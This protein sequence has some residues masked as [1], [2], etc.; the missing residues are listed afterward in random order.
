MFL[1]HTNNAIKKRDALG[2]IGFFIKL[3]V[4]NILNKLSERLWTKATQRFWR[5]CHLFLANKETFIFSLHYS[6]K[7]LGKEKNQ[8]Q[9]E[10]FTP[11]KLHL[12]S[13][14]R[15]ATTQKKNKCVGKGFKVISPASS[16][17]QV[18]VHT[19]IPNGS[20]VGKTSRKNVSVVTNK[21]LIRKGR[22]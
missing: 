19:S 21:L 5:G 11:N 7:V 13:L 2:V 18:S 14:P 16:S 15:K 1:C 9:N 6:T 22:L 8:M 10:N 17:S 12:I 20:S 4:H 3:Q